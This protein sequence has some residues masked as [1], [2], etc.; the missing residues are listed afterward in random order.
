MESGM[1]R[2]RER[3]Q[4]VRGEGEREGRSGSEQREGCSAGRGSL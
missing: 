4:K 1:G 2:G 3:V